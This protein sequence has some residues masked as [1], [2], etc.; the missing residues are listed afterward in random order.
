MVKP[1]K[2]IL[3]PPLISQAH[4]YNVEIKHLLNIQSNITRNIDIGDTEINPI[5][6]LD[7]IIIMTLT[8]CVMVKLGLSLLVLILYFVGFLKKKQQVQEIVCAICDKC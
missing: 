3:L 2:S 8:S 4:N 1:S 5:G 6:H 7:V